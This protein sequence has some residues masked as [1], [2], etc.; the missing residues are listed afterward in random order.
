DATEEQVKSVRPECFAQIE[1]VVKSEFSGINP[2]ILGRTTIDRLPHGDA[3][4]ALS[5]PY[6]SSTV[7]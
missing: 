4:K 7:H 1:S 5:S 6:S 2:N 3:L